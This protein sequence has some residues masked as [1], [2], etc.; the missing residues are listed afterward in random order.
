MLSKLKTFSYR[1]LKFFFKQAGLGVTSYD[2]LVNLRSISRNTSHQ[3]LEL[4]RTLK[5]ANLDKAIN[6]LL[7]SKSQIGQDFFVLSET[8]FKKHGYFVEIGASNGYD[9]SNTL[10]LES[11]FGWNGLLVEPAKC[12]EQDL[13]KN[14]PATSIE[15]SCV[16][17][18]TG[19][20]IGFSE[21]KVG[22]LS[23]VDSFVNQDLHSSNRSNSKRYLVATI[24][25]NDLLKKYDAPELIDY[26]SIDTEGSEFEIL[27]SFDFRKNRINI[28]TVEH[29]FTNKRER[30]YDLLVKNGYRR[31]FKSISKFEDWYV[32]V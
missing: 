19:L 29:N 21:A 3:D 30:I 26:L 11:Q 17:S 31:K 22:E 7:N 18:E 28:I 2:N 13:R 23:T 5:P 4:I 15:T 24:S 12:W 27:N 1:L 14:R 25:L 8:N 32:K 10:L 16:W 20:R 6:L 9:L